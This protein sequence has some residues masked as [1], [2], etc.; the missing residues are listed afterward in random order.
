MPTALSQAAKQTNADLLVT[1]T[2]PY[3]GNLRLHCYGII[4]SVPIPVLN[5]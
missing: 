4:R 3:G 1:G 2:Y 5:V